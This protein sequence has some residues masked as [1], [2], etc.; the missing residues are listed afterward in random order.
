M[1]HDG[2]LFSEGTLLKNKNKNKNTQNLHSPQFQVLHV[3]KRSCP[4]I[5]LNPP[6]AD[7][8]VP[9]NSPNPIPMG[10]TVSP[11]SRSLLAPLVFLIETSGR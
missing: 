10:I 3:C 11:G 2:A 8:P 1:I 5:I 7:L 6:L 9:K 4:W